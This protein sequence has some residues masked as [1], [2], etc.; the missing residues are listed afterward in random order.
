MSQ[1]E[2]N[3]LLDDHAVSMQA[4][5]SKQEMEKQRVKK[6]L[7]NKRN[8][9]K[10]KKAAKKELE[11]PLFVDNVKTKKSS[12]S[13]TMTIGNGYL[14]NKPVAEVKPVVTATVV[15][16]D[17]NKRK[18]SSDLDSDSDLKVRKLISCMIHTKL[19]FNN[20]L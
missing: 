12:I 2:I 15:P 8:K 16:E 3:K 1:S 19:L 20:R 18:D 17:S 7:E 10:K 5:R 14:R 4:L 13:D 11:D 6:K 9:N